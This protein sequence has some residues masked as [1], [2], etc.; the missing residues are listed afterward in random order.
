MVGSRGAQLTLATQ[1]T[2]LSDAMPPAIVITSQFVNFV[3]QNCR[4]PAGSK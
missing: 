2:E 4:D 1:V 3:V